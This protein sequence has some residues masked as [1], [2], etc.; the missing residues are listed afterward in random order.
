MLS[1]IT[2][3]N[4]FV[5]DITATMSTLFTDLSGYITLILG[6]VLGAIIIDVVIG[7]IRK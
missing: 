5:A 4:G 1:I 7:A 2:L 3:P 6:V